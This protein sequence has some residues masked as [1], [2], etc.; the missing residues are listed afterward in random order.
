MT[1]APEPVI[2]DMCKKVHPDSD[3]AK[4]DAWC[5]KQE[6]NDPAERNVTRL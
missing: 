2:C 4:C 1:T 3:N 5:K 6:E